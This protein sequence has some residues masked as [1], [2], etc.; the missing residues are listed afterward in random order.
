MAIKSVWLGVFLLPFITHLSIGRSVTTKTLQ[1]NPKGID[2]FGVCIENNEN[3][4][5]NQLV[6]KKEHGSA[7]ICSEISISKDQTLIP[8]N[9]ML[10]IQIPM[11]TLDERRIDS[12]QKETEFHTQHPPKLTKDHDY[13]GHH[14]SRKLS[15]NEIDQLKVM[16]LKRHRNEDLGSIFPDKPFIPFIPW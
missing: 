16:S 10:C 4:V 8:Q 11:A 13:E 1:L 9:D 2:Y 5:Y 12:Y 6:V 3:K 7:Y 14:N 15:I